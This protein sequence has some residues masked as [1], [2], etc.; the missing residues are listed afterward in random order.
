L[1][2]AFAPDRAFGSA[3]DRIQTLVPHAE[4]QPESTPR[5]IPG[6]T[7]R[8]LGGLSF[9]LV[10]ALSIGSDAAGWQAGG[11]AGRAAISTL[12]DACVREI[13][14]GLL[15]VAP[16]ATRIGGESGE[17]GRETPRVV[18]DGRRR[19]LALVTSLPPPLA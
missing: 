7:L 14:L 17:A 1:V 11:R 8:A 2:D 9:L 12:A 10:V 15:R 3:F 19:L 13:D 4:L 18:V 6:L 5:P 16:R